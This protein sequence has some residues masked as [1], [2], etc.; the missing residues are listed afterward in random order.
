M[1]NQSLLKR[2]NTVQNILNDLRRDII[3]CR[4]KN[5]T[6]VTELG[7]SKKYDCSRAAVRS[8]FI[9]L[10]KEGLIISKGNG[11]KEISC[12]SKEDID[13]LYELRE[14]LELTSINH[15][16]NKKLTDLSLVFDVVNKF[17][18]LENLNVEEVLELDAQFHTALIKISKNKALIQAWLNISDVI[19]EV[20]SMNMTESEEYRNW[21]LHSFRE[22]HVELMSVLMSSPDKMYELLGNHIKDAHEISLKAVQKLENTKG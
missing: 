3:L 14:Y 22:R 16:Y 17:G 10:E 21:F 1:S 18:N 13:N 2:S 7:I 20:F 4:Y 5:H 11:T 8:A 9:V 6:Q 12:L 15:F 19:K